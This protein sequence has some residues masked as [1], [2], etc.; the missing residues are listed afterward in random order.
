[1]QAE[2]LF[3]ESILRCLKCLFIFAVIFSACCAVDASYLNSSGEVLGWSDWECLSATNVIENSAS[4]SVAPAEGSVAIVS[5][6]S[7]AV[8]YNYRNS[9]GLWN[10]FENLGWL[11][12]GNAAVAS[13]DGVLYLAIRGADDAL[14]VNKKVS[15]AWS[16]W[17]RWNGSIS[18]D[19]VAAETSV[20]LD[21]GVK[22]ADGR[23]WLRRE[24][25]SGA[26]SAWF[27]IEGVSVKD[28]LS[29]ASEEGEVLIAARNESN[30]VYVIARDALGNWGAWTGIGGIGQY[31]PY[32]YME[33]GVV[34]VSVVGSDG[35][36]WYTRRV[37]GVWQQ[38]TSLGGSV[39]GKPQIA[40]AGGSILIA[41]KGSDGGL[42][43]R[44]NSSA[45]TW[46]NWNG[47]PNLGAYSLFGVAAGNGS[48]LFSV[49]GWDKK[50]YSSFYHFQQP[51]I[52]SFDLSYINYSIA[53]LSGG[54]KEISFYLSNAQYE[55]KITYM[56]RPGENYITKS[57][58]LALKDAV[59]G[60]FN[61]YNSAA[62]DAYVS[63]ESGESVFRIGNSL[64]ERSIRVTG[65]RLETFEVKNKISGKGYSVKSEEFG[66]Q[67]ANV[68]A[69]ISIDLER[70]SLNSTIM[71]Q[72]Y[73]RGFPVLYDDLFFWVKHPLHLSKTVSAGSDTYLI[74]RMHPITPLNASYHYS[75]YE[76]VLGVSAS[77]SASEAYKEFLLGMRSPRDEFYY[78]YPTWW[79]VRYRV[80][81][82]MVEQNI[83]TL[84]AELLDPYNVSFDTYRLD[85][86]WTEINSIWQPDSVNFPGGLQPVADAIHSRNMKMGIWVSPSSDYPSQS[87]VWAEQ[88]GY[89]VCSKDWYWKNLCF[90]DAPGKKSY[91]SE[92]RSRLSDYVSSY[93]LSHIM[94]DVFFP[95][96]PDGAEEA[97]QFLEIQQHLRDLNPDMR[98]E[99]SWA[100]SPG[101][102]LA[103]DWLLVPAGDYPP[104][105]S[106][107]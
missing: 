12:K 81:R 107:P 62:S 9:L 77:G 2:R 67:L 1:M 23:L 51:A 91:Y 78:V 54:G 83:A 89:F 52:T 80:N 66:A 18:A 33:N 6:V 53:D 20:G 94:W 61:H 95:C 24:Y 25:T 40:G 56:V 42:W 15:G 30:G 26:L 71:W 47:V 35:A 50:I 72:T 55:A 74:E 98:Y 86:S 7:S 44:M 64:L 92:L 106:R 59:S 10:G 93:D 99:L 13:G 97:D 22:G 79:T 88:D 5:T 104:G 4:L 103:T 82:S 75:A 90:F 102:L 63:V 46:S 45:G 58:G 101:Y 14:W 69:P 21:V 76:A 60:P 85:D 100:F 36:L 43:F 84:E 32:I 41:V 37:G 70:I 8:V 17:A 29:I 48:F 105:T 34:H 57:L 27:P 65:G 87:K 96:H 38:W 16:G 73:M 31:D 19:P 11:M 68:S 3:W 28:G 49:I 39:L